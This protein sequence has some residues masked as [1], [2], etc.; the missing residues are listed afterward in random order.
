VPEGEEVPLID[1]IEIPE[2]YREKYN[3]LCVELKDHYEGGPI[4]EFLSEHI[5]DLL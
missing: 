4:P 1:P 2:T 3:E 5:K